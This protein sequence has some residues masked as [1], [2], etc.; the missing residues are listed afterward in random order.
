[1]SDTTDS[2]SLRRRLGLIAGPLA[3]FILLLIPTPEGMSA[4]GQKVAAI[5]ALMAIWWV[6]EAIPIPATSLLPIALFPTLK[7]MSAADA[8][9]PFANHLIFLFMGGFM[10]AI[11]MQRWNLHRRIAL[12][13]IKLIGFS[14]SRLVLGFMVATAVLSAFV[15]NTATAVM[16]MPI[17]VAI[18]SQA[19]EEIAALKIDVPEKAMN[20]FGI[21]LMLGIA[22]AASIGGIATI[23]GTP[24]NTVLAN[25]LQSTYGYEITFGKWLM[26]GGPLVIIFIPL[27]WLWLTKVANSM[28][29]LELPN[30]DGIIKDELAKLG[31]LSKGE[32][33]TLIVFVLTAVAWIVRG[34]LNDLLPPEIYEHIS[35]VSDS[36][37]AM[38]G[39]IA[40]F[41][42]PVDLKKC[43][44]VLTWEAAA[45][46][47]WGVLVLFGGGLS[48]A[49]GFKESGLSAWTIDQVS[50]LQGMPVIVLIF[51]L[52][53]LVTFLTELTSNTATTNL[54]M[55]V[56]GGVAIGLGE[57]P[58]L[59]LAPAAI[60]ASCA[61]MLPV[62]TPPNA[63]VF[64]SGRL[65]IPDMM[66]SGFALNVMGVFLVT[67][68]VYFILVPVFGIVIG[69]LPEWVK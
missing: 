48:L 51:G 47:P 20:A 32:R 44:F 56:L 46:L 13:I 40:L 18:I 25:Y 11:A 58:L 14:P 16:M 54:L 22:Y 69:E 42:I 45:K 6:T 31:G 50:F 15:S 23:I 19:T 55:P 37:I 38:A 52:C 57:S 35:F 39:A 60:S 62:A 53:L 8:T 21:N 3:F 7:I 26:V 49:A 4:D 10:I 5:A 59:L 63:I 17:G 2:A 43:E 29:G 33:Y 67:T 12:L 65:T 64:G 66:K 28:K 24:P 36:T 1:M 61:F 34:F 41:C 27:T 30:S 68:L 9:A